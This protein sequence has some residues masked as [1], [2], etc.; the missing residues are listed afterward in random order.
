MAKWFDRYPGPDQMVFGAPAALHALE[1]KLGI[2]AGQAMRGTAYGSGFDIGYLQMNEDLSLSASWI[3]L[4]G[5]QPLGPNE[6][7]TELGREFRAMILAYVTSQRMDRPIVCHV[8][9]LSAPTQDDVNTIIE[10]LRSRGVPFYARMDNVY[11]GLVQENG[12]IHYD[13]TADAGMLLEFAPSV[14]DNLTNF[15]LPPRL[16]DN[17]ETVQLLPGTLVRPLAR[18]NVVENAEA[19]IDRFRSM[20]DWPDE[21]DVDIVDGDGQRSLILKPLNGLSAVWELVQPTR[22]DSRAGQ[23]LQR[24]GAGAW[25]NRLGVFGLDALLGDLEARG[26][27]WADVGPGPKGQRRVALNPGDLHGLSLE[28]EDMPVVFRGVGAGRV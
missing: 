5:I 8:Q 25:V 20:L 2:P 1:T 12:H 27:R 23:V 18:V 13:P 7:D 24:Y 16:P 6:P 22:S 11:I 4:M 17:P 15:I 28:L 21:E 9:P 14:R 10:M 19:I 3:Q 26:T